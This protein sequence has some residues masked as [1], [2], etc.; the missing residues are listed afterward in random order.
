M[1]RLLALLDPLLRRAPLIVEPD[2]RP[3]RQAQIRDDETDSR[4]Q[5]PEVELHLRH[6]SPRRFPT[7]RLVQKALVPDHWFMTGAAQGTLQ[8]FRKVPLQILVGRYAD[9][10]LHAALL[11]RFVDLRFGKGRVRPE[12]Y[13]LA[14]RLLTLDLRQ[15]QFIPVFGAV[16]V[17]RAQLRRQAVPV[18]IEQKQWVIADRL[19]VPVVRAALL[20]TMNRTLAGVHVEHD[21]V[22]A[23]KTLGLASVSRFNAISQIRF[24]SL[25][26]SSVS[27]QCKVEVSAGLRSQILCELI[28]RKVG[29][30]ASRSA[31][32]RSS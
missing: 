14:L 15:Q 20:L 6:Y 26:S 30:A 24:S 22:G 8:Q 29:S 19:K 23:V 5:F 17:S 25:V 9:G 27:N 4:E 10:I 7:G 31:S 28:N 18:T 16:H 1:R 2:Y 21:A 3:A 11:Q 13:F 32:L 12:S